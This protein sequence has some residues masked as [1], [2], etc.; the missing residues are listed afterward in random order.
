MA[1]LK[2][3]SELQQ[4]L[5]LWPAGSNGEAEEN[6]AVAQLDVLGKTLGYGRLA[7]LA[8]AVS[9]LQ[10]YD[11]DGAKSTEYGCVKSAHFKLNAWQLP[12]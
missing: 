7:Q 6:K 1:K 11:T 5:V 8:Q 9:D 12:R 10:L 3:T 4:L 2:S